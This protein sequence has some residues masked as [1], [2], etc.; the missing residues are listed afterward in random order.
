MVISETELRQR[1]ER[2]LNEAGLGAVI[3]Y[4]SSQFL[5]VGEGP[6]VELVLT[7]ASRQSD[8]AF[9]LTRVSDELRAE[10]VVLD[11]IVRSLWQVERI[12][13]VGLART[14]DGG[15]RTA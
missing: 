9:V 6:F 8:A 14:P 2:E 5:I 15:L 12:W 13:Y 7:D 4:E 3:D 1:F 10:G 11:G